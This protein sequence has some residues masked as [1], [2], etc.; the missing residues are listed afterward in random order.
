[1]NDAT[2]KIIETELNSLAE[3]I[4]Q[5]HRAAGQVASG[6]TINSINVQASDEYVGLYAKSYFGVNETGRKPGNVPKG[7]YSIILKWIEDKG[8]Q[9]DKPKTAAY[10]ISRKIASEGSKLFRDGGRSDIYS[11]VVDESKRKIESEIG[12]QAITE[13]TNIKLN[14][15]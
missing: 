13:L 5:N 9:F 6:K 8:L 1:M 4:K 10:F 2:R 15:K 3:R 7:F 12:R 11:I 14:I